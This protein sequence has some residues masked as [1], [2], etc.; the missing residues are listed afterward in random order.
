MVFGVSKCWNQDIICVPAYSVIFHFTP[1][2]LVML[3]N[4]FLSL[5]NIKG[6]NTFKQQNSKI[7]QVNQH[8]E[9]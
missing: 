4:T 6:K 7:G 8:W 2:F 3:K 1:F 5:G 9:S